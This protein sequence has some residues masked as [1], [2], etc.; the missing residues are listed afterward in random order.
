MFDDETYNPFRHNDDC[1]RYRDN[2]GVTR[3]HNS[4]YHGDGSDF[5][6]GRSSCRYCGRQLH[7]CESTMFATCPNCG[8]AVHHYI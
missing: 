7:S 5:S 8:T 3:A 2:L 6:Y 1:H 4:L